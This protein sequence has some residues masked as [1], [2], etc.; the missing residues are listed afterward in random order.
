MNTP[1]FIRLADQCI[2]GKSLA[3]TDYHALIHTPDTQVFAMMAGADY[4]R[5][6]FFQNQVHLCAI[7]N[8]KSGR[9]S[10]DCKFCSQSKFVDTHVEVYPLRSRTQLE[11]E[12]QDMA[13]TPVQR[14]SMVTSGRGL[15][16]NEVSQVAHAAASARDEQIHICASLGIQTE[17]EFKELR[18]AGVTRYHHNLETSRSYFP[19]ICT[20]HSYDERI[21]T[22]RNAQKA[23]MTICCG[24][25]FGIGETLDQ[26]L[27]LALE[28][29]TLDVDAVP[30][31]F[32]TPIPGTPM[33]NQAP[34]GPLTCLKIIALMRYALPDKDILVCGGRTLN[35]GPLAPQVFAAG[36]NGIMTGNYLTTEGNQL[37]ADLKLLNTL[38]LEARPV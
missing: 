14:F 2:Q 11:K 7:S 8:A 17:S 30:V 34:L 29:Q 3:E 35:L 22:I 24:G 21:Q 25:I 16:P 37:D 4:I 19:E 12:I 6:H 38:G 26:V 1:D 31:N 36:A 23:G 9:C 10:E 33:E 20:T 28:L 13:Q 5:R 15:S 18:K 27:E 32:L